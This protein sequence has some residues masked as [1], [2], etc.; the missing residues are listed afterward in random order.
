MAVCSYCGTSFLWGGSREGSRRFCNDRCRQAGVLLSIADQVPAEVVREHVAAVHRGPCPSCK[1]PG[2]IDVYNSYRVW[3]ALLLTSW[4]TRPHVCCR[5][6]ATKRQLG[7]AAFSFFL[8]WWGVPWGLLMTPLQVARNIG[9]LM[10]RPDPAVPTGQFEKLIKL[11]L[12][13]RI[14]NHNQ[15]QRVAT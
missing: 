10:S 11:D 12:A 3:S 5:G 1:G 6:C 14:V 7:D 8:G 4:Q 2:P 13:Q 15:Q 9:G